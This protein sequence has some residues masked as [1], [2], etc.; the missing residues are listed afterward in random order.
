MGCRGSCTTH[1]GIK[2][3]STR[4]DENETNLQPYAVLGSGFL[5]QRSYL[6]ALTG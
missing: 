2:R 3:Q 6:E 5:T 4:L 1:A